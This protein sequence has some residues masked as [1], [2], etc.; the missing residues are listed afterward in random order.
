MPDTQSSVTQTQRNLFNALQR[1][2]KWRMVFA[3][4]QLGTR[5]KGDPECDAVRDHRELSILT[6]AE[7]NTLTRLMID[8]GIFTDDEFETQLAEEAEWLSNSYEEKFPGCKATD[9]GIA[10]DVDRVTET[11]KGWRP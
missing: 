8:K 3:G 6:R 4:W 5:L 9:D 10:M 1:L 7:V 11:M 2:A